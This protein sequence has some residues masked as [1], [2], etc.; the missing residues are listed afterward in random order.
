MKTSFKQAAVVEE[1]ETPVTDTTLAT[2]SPTNIVALPKAKGFFG[3][4]KHTDIRHPR[5]NLVQKSSDAALIT[6]AGLG[7]LVL[8]K[9]IVLAKIGETINVTALGAG[10]DYVQKVEFGSDDTPAVFRTEDEVL[11]A[12]GSFNWKD[13]ASGNFF[14]R[15]AHVEFAISAPDGLSDNELA[16][17]PYEF[18]ETPYALAVYT[19][20][21]SAYTS[22]AV[23]LAT[24]CNINKVMRQGPHYG[25]V[26]LTIQSR[27]K[28]GK[29]WYVPTI[30]YAG[31]NSPEFIQFLTE[32]EP[33]L[34][35]G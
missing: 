20:A 29:T 1:Q 25:N 26:D 18:E 9:E 14:Q 8:A 24:L 27:A 5:I 34:A 4:W 28:A 22:M 3:E 6:L 12:G 13:A 31:A 16:L 17:F 15:R 19:V 10:K 35:N 23:E 32:I 30:K 11:Q 7:A 33:N 2:K 21:S